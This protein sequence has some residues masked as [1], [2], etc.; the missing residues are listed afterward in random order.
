MLPPLF[1]KNIQNA[2]KIFTTRV[3]NKIFGD[4]LGKL[5]R[6]FA[7]G[8]A[9]YA[10]YRY[11]N[12]RGVGGRPAVNPMLVAPIRGPM[13]RVQVPA[14]IAA[15]SVRPAYVRHVDRDGNAV[16][17]NRMLANN[18]TRNLLLVDWDTYDVP[19]YERFWNVFGFPLLRVPN[20]MLPTTVSFGKDR[21]A[22]WLAGEL[23]VV[24]YRREHLPT[25]LVHEVDAFWA[26]QEN[27]TEREFRISVERTIHLLRDVDVHPILYNQLC[28][29]VPVVCYMR[30]TTADRLGVVPWSSG[31]SQGKSNLEEICQFLALFGGVI[32][33]NVV[34][35]R[36]GG[37]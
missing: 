1:L 22:G 19:Q 30:S 2:I 15:L 34:S 7:F 4:R 21:N 9:L 6:T 3:N 33:I 16:P 17:G 12:R 26:T 5:T 29:D 25:G 23:H 32:L 10:M 14:N 8:L 36:L 37:L 27:H 13:G 24:G 28:W 20:M 35:R 31:N 11:W 18:N